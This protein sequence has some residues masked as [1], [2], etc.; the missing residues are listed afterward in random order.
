MIL[1]IFMYVCFMYSVS[2]KNAVCDVSL[3]LPTQGGK[4][5]GGNRVYDL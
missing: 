4:G 1:M 5:L 2:A 3:S